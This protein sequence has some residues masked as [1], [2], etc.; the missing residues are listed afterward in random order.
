MT[1]AHTIEELLAVHLDDGAHVSPYL[2]SFGMRL[3][4]RASD[5]QRQDLK[6]FVPLVVGTAGDGL[7]EK[8]RWLGA[9]YAIRTA[10][11]KWLERASLTDHAQQLRTLVPITDAASYDAAR[12]AVQDARDAAYQ[13]R[14]AVYGGKTRW[15]YIRDAVKARLDVDVAAAV[16]AAAAAAAAAAVDVAVDVAVA[17]A[18]AV[19][20]AAVAA[21]AVD[22]AVDVAVAAAVA[23]VAAVDVDVA[24]DVAVAA[25]AAAAAA[26]V[27]VADAVAVAGTQSYWDIRKTAYKAARAVY[28]ERYADL[29]AES[30]TEALAL[31]DRLINPGGTHQ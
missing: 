13:A 7:D 29:I 25:A 26:V 5:E 10:A 28:E 14:R 9:D 11:P 1:T 17:A 21:A 16:A 18:V 27:A 24:V 8:R 6:R 19:V 4:D 22:V 30:W 31:F 2:R 15:D 12:T 3:N 23:V 20:A